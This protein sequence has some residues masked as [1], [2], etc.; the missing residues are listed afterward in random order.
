MIQLKCPGV[1]RDSENVSALQFYFNRRCSD[2]EM[3][4]L[5]EVIQRAVM[6]LPRDSQ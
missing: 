4:F 3:Q 2:D 1:G 5:H 6:M